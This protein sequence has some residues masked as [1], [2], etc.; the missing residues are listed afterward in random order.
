MDLAD[1]GEEILYASVGKIGELARAFEGQVARNPQEYWILQP[2]LV[3]SNVAN[4]VPPFQI[5][6]SVLARWLHNTKTQCP[7]ILRHLLNF[8]RQYVCFDPNRN[9]P[10]PKEIV[11]PLLRSHAA[12]YLLASQTTARMTIGAALAKLMKYAKVFASEGVGKHMAKFVDPVIYKY[13]AE[14]FCEAV[15]DLEQVRKQL[16]LSDECCSQVLQENSFLHAVTQ[17]LHSIQR[18]ASHKNFI[19]AIF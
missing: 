3:Y 1:M 2:N 12:T 19:R 11:Q 9:Q 4:G 7:I 18:S 6:D 8:L 10:V 16:Q 5:D 17:P 14:E 15:N 13:I